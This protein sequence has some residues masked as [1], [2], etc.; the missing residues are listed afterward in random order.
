M[1]TVQAF[2]LQLFI[3]KFYNLILNSELLSLFCTSGSLQFTIC[4]LLFL[5]L[6]RAKTVQLSLLRSN[7]T[8]L[9]KLFKSDLLTLLL[10][11]C[12]VFFPPG[13]HAV[14]RS[15]SP[16]HSAHSVCVCM[17]LAEMTKEEAGEWLIFLLYLILSSNV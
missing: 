4:F 2:L 15:H 14:Q 17:C 7:F 6:H 3:F 10:N 11:H 9:A 13:V 12:V 5:F 16:L 8:H 1:D